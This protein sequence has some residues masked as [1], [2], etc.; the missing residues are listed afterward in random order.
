[1]CDNPGRGY[2]DASMHSTDRNRPYWRHRQL[3]FVY[4]GGTRRTIYLQYLSISLSTISCITPSSYYTKIAPEYYYYCTTHGVVSTE[5]SHSRDPARWTGDLRSDAQPLLETLKIRRCRRRV[6]EL[7]AG[8]GLEHQA[9]RG[10]CEIFTVGV[11]E[12]S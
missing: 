11:I 1:M 3:P 2:V 7:C 5:T 9:Q 8:E 4:W 6:S 12:G 10:S